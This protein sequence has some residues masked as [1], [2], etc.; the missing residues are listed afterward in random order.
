MTI[1]VDEGQS[2]AAE[3]AM[4]EDIY[5][6]TNLLQAIW[7]RA[8]TIILV[9]IVLTGATVGFSL[10]QTPMY[11]SSIKLF[12]G[13]ENAIVE[14]PSDVTGLQQLTLT[15]AEG[16]STRPI[17]EAVIRQENLRISPQDLLDNLSVEQIG[18]TQFIQVTY[19]DSSPKRAQR[20]ANAIG[21]AFSKK[22]SGGSSAANAISAT[23][24]ERAALPD[25]PVSPNTMRNGL[26]TLVA[27]LM[28]G[29]GLTL[30]LKL[31][32]DSWHSP[33]EVEQITGVLTIGVIPQYS[34]ARMTKKIT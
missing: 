17:A 33:E 28:L 7:R 14:T 15:M 30:L 25:E 22:V 23:V 2:R 19:K 26:L 20:V 4:Y 27:A 29:V 11:E 18:A 16:V 9:A 32:D 24:W 8:W 1:A 5:S 6:L 3:G 31:L 34:T 21:E 10:L 13:Q 12:I